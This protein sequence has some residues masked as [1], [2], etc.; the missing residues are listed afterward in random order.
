MNEASDDSFAFLCFGFVTSCLVLAWLPPIL[1]FIWDLRSF[2]KFKGNLYA[3]WNWLTFI[4]RTALLLMIRPGLVTVGFKSLIERKSFTFKIV[5]PLVLRKTIRIKVILL[6]LFF[7]L[8]S[9]VLY[10]K[11]SFDPHEILGV[12]KDAEDKVIRKSYRKLSMVYHPDK[13]KTE[14]AQIMYAKVRKAYKMIADPEAYEEELANQP[15][16]AGEVGVALPR[17]LLDPEYRRYAA[18]LLLGTLFL[19]PIALIMMLRSTDNDAVV[20][21]TI[22]QLQWMQEQYDYFYRLMGEPEGCTNGKPEDFCAG[23]TINDTEYLVGSQFVDLCNDDVQKSLQQI[24]NVI[25]TNKHY[26]T[27]FQQFNALHRNKQDLLMQLRGCIA[28]GERPK[29]QMVANLQSSNKRILQT[30]EMLQGTA[31]QTFSD[32]PVDPDGMPPSRKELRA[33]PKQR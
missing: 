6:I 24:F 31:G 22:E 33:R 5:T 21:Q 1:G 8:L 18:P 9:I 15:Q 26:I 16:S 32:G 30:L 17:F 27:N 25:R 29:K 2:D 11:L 12:P 28:M 3:L 7:F 23:W 4:P 10:Q 13:N 14:E 19:F 20:K